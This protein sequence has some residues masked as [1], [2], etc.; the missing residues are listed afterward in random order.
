[1]PL[2]LNLPVA[3]ARASATVL[4]NSVLAY[5]GS[6]SQAQVAA[7]KGLHASGEVAPILSSIA[8]SSPQALPFLASVRA[9]CATF[10]SGTLAPWAKDMDRHALDL[11]RVLYGPAMTP[12]L[13]LDP[14]SPLPWMQALVSQAKVSETVRPSGDGVEFLRKFGWRRQVHGLHHAAQP[15]ELLAVLY[16]AF[17]GGGMPPSIATLDATTG[18]AGE[19]DT[20]SLPPSNQGLWGPSPSTVWGETPGTSPPPTTAAFYSVGS[21]ASIGKGLKLGTR[22]IYTHAASL[23][24]TAPHLNTFCTLSPIP[25]FMAWL[26]VKNPLLHQGLTGR[27]WWREESGKALQFQASQ[28]LLAYLHS[29]ERGAPVC[30]V[31]AFHLGNGARLGR[32]CGGADATPGGLKR[33]AGF[34][35]NYVYS[36]NGGEGLKETME[37]RA[38]RFASEPL[39]VLGEQVPSLVF[40]P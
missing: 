35:V 18:G 10:E 20:A 29:H 33:S 17:V 25:G 22:I 16:T 7:L 36:E 26:G 24:L 13:A 39:K 27:V 12:L 40:S 30:R 23:A 15:S 19:G 4:T 1:M 9:R 6:E 31:A 37:D 28:A 14:Y 11:L 21:P 5:L 8:S 34:M 2:L 3:S 38:P 32:I